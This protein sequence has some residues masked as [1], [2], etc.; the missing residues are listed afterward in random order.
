MTERTLVTGASGWL[1]NRLC[2]TIGER[3]R[4]IRAMVIPE[5]REHPEIL[6]LRENLPGDSSL[7]VTVGDVRDPESLDEACRDIDT[8]FHTVGVI[9]PRNAKTFYEINAEG[10]RNTVEACA[11]MGV[12]RFVYISSNAAQGF[13]R[14]YEERDGVRVPVP[15]TEEMPCHPESD[16]GRSKLQAEGIVNGAHEEHG[17]ETV[18]IRPPMY[19]GPRLPERT[20]RLYNMILGGLPIVGGV[21]V[22][23]GGNVYRSVVFIDNVCEA[24]LLAETSGKADGETYWIADDGMI[25]WREYLE[26]VAAN[27][28]AELS[29]FSLPRFVAKAL[30]MGDKAAGWVG[31]YQQLFHVLGEMGRD[32]VCSI[33]KA[34]R[35][36]GYR[37]EVSTEKGIGRT[38]EW[39]IENDLVA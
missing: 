32:C 34:K 37:A 12:R 4:D 15:L 22:F 39:M 6:R 36:L 7:E 30:E 28:D 17:I 21:P 35:D 11:R 8:V 29:L 33:E 19:Y 38:V 10:T 26:I 23:G 2:Q 14:V 1:G 31:M 9:H 20:Q 13:N 3:G 5:H 16:Y 18:I 24:L 25:T 27:L